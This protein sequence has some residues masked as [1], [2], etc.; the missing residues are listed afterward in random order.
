MRETAFAS[1]RLMEKP[2]KPTRSLLICQALCKMI[3]ILAALSVALIFARGAQTGDRLGSPTFSN[4]MSS[5]LTV[6]ALGLAVAD[7]TGDSHPDFAIAKLNGLD[8]PRAQYSIE[9]RLSEGGGQSLRLTAPFG[10]LVITPQDVTG[11]GT[12]DLIVRSARSHIPVAV[13]LNDG[14]GHFSA[15]ESSSF[16]QALR[17][18]PC[19]LG[20]AT[21]QFY[22]GATPIPT[23]SYTIAGWSASIRNPQVEVGAVSLVNCSVPT[24]L[25]LPFGSNRAPPAL[26]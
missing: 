3:P 9:V 24:H 2:T 18:V 1:D 11:D 4:R 14:R 16:A 23:E 13:F 21:D 8:S 6:P 22:F 26:A 5:P 20:P 7:F 12:L 25:L 17:D 15:A 10:G 19:E